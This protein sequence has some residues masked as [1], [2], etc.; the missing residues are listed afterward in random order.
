MNELTI[1]DV[2]EAL[3]DELKAIARACNISLNEAA[4][5]VLR[6]G[7]GLKVGNSLDWFIGTWSDEEAREFMK[8]QRVFETIDEAMWE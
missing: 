4:L 3:L 8:S 5:L 7:A 2:D 1:H 6:K